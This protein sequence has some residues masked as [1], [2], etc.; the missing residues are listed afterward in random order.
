MPH[1]KEQ[2]ELEREIL[3][4]TDKLIE[5]AIETSML[6]GEEFEAKQ[7]EG[8]NI[9]AKLAD[10]LEKYLGGSP[11]HFE[12][13]IQELTKQKLPDENVLKSFGDFKLY[14]EEA[15]QKGLRIYHDNQQSV[16]N[17]KNIETT[18]C[19]QDETENREDTN[20][21]VDIISDTSDNTEETLEST[22]ETVLIETN[23]PDVIVDEEKERKITAEEIVDVSLPEHSEIDTAALYC[24]PNDAP[25]TSDS[26]STAGL[27][28]DD[29]QGLETDTVSSQDD[30]WM[31]AL[32]LVFPGATIIKDHTLKGLSFSYYI[33]EYSIAID[34][35]P[36][37]KREA[38]WKEYYCR[39]E[40]IKHVSLEITEV[41]RIRQIV[42]NL[43][44]SL[45]QNTN[46]N[47][48]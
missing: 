22:E 39:Q 8:F 9:V 30:S 6:T 32:K 37:N 33:P 24:D 4:L 19:S 16:L 40:K 1:R 21:N 44:R 23:A 38:V 13:V 43:R 26:V 35:N 47:I 41:S 15:I 34:L 29:C 36:P 27:E 25:G 28:D 11:E 5:N 42:R 20:S 48:S 18:G 7:A 17:E 2:Q 3:E 12:Q 31:Q 14:L 45:A 10:V 46:Q